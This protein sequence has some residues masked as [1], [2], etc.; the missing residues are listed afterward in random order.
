MRRRDR[1]GI[2]DMFEKFTERSRKALSLAQNEAQR[3]NHNYIGTEHILLGLVAEGDG[4]AAK[5]LQH[6]GVELPAVRRQ[7]EFIVGRG[8]RPVY[9]EIGMTPRGKKVLQLAVDEARRMNHH[10]IGTEHLLLG[11]IREGEGIAAGVLES[12]GVNLEQARNEVLRII[13]QPGVGAAS[14]PADT[15]PSPTP[16]T[17]SAPK[18]NVV[19]CRLDDAAVSALD[20]LV[21]A[22]IRST[23]SDA[24]A[25][26]ISAGIE[27]HR[28][29]FDRVNAT[30]SEIRKLRRE[31]QHIAHQVTNGETGKT[32]PED[33]DNATSNSDD[34]DV[35]ETDETGEVKDPEEPEDL[36]D[37][38]RLDEPP[39]P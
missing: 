5:A 1:D 36:D 38:G 7:V 33:K 31:A 15:A 26:L 18:N 29:L 11:M 20:A 19:T 14:K 13:G 30:I 3:L 23:R 32:A 6:L 34:K 22:G 35:D 9:G 10:Y 16:P 17:A 28:E 39:T 24:A 12:L 37:L 25:W 8:D 2:N 21:E 4:V 27:A